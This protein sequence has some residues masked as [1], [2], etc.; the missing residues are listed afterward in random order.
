MQN[1]YYPSVALRVRKRA[2]PNAENRKNH[3]ETF[4]TPPN[5]PQQNM[6]LFPKHFS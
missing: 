3:I 4:I 2:T 6:K 1:Y 5:K